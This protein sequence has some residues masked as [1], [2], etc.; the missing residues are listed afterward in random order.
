MKSVPYMIWRILENEDVVLERHSD[1]AHI[2]RSKQ[3]LLDAHLKGDL[4][5]DIRSGSD[6]PESRVTIKGPL[7]SY[8]EEHQAIALRKMAYIKLAIQRLGERPS[9]EKL[10]VYLNGF[11]QQVGDKEPPGA[12]TVYRWWRDWKQ[13]GE[14]IAVLLP[15]PNPGRVSR[16]LQDY[17]LLLIEVADELIYQPVPG[18][19]L[20]AY[21]L[22]KV[23]VI[24]ANSLKTVPLEI[25]SKATFY[26]LLNK[27][28]DPYQLVLMQEGRQAAEKA[29]RATGEGV[30][31]T[32]ILE[33]VEIDHTPINLMVIDDVTGEVCGRPSLTVIIDHYSKMPLGIYVGF[34]P[35][36]SVSVMRAMRNAILP[37]NDIEK[38]FPEFP[39]KWPA[40]GIFGLMA[41][42][43]GSEFHDKQL[44]RMCN[45]LNIELLFCPKK[46][47]WFKG[48]IERYVGTIN[49]SVCNK[50]DGT[51]F[52]SIGERGEYNSVAEARHTLKDLERYILSW[53]INIYN[54]DFHEGLGD[55]PLNVWTEGLKLVEPC[56]PAS[57]DSLDL[58]LT[59]E[60]LRKVNHEGV[61]LLRLKYNSAELGLLRR[62]LKSNS[63][64]RVRVDPENIG[65]VWIYD[66]FSTSFFL[67]PCRTPEV[68]EGVSLRQMVHLLKGRTDR[69]KAAETD[70]LMQR[71]VEF[72]EEIRNAKTAKNLRKRTQ[73]ARLTQ[74]PII[75]IGQNLVKEAR[76]NKE[77]LSL[78][79]DLE[80]FDIEWGE[81]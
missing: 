66:D 11:S 32:R 3:E 4:S 29:F 34:E 67:V 19:K 10:K 14:D 54:V 63:S 57:R 45:E 55:T 27:V 18:T 44:K 81:E 80:D 39:C 64:V 12:Y 62:Q 71:K 9:C 22:F 79:D 30:R 47:S 40:F 25:P 70:E 5:F 31:T 61:Q 16:Y 75:N 69:R 35:P 48:S 33:R 65:S 20:D 36:S 53:I 24:E 51:T 8:P 28:L 15:K 72:V 43:N 77:S 7:D 26:R 59:K 42:D 50:M 41:C 13:S 74:L 2:M 17:R 73:A 60:Y 76:K 1:L 78:P 38:R 52:S 21:H 49:D 58:T 6:L 56:L 46:H 37:K 68:A 23:K